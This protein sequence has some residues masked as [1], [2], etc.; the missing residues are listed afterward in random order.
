MISVSLQFGGLMLRERR[1][2]EKSEH[3]HR[4]EIASAQ[5]HRK[6]AHGD[7][8]LDVSLSTPLGRLS[9]RGEI[10]PGE[11]EAGKRYA[12]LALRYLQT[13]GSP[14]PF[15]DGDPPA[16]LLPSDE[17]CAKAKRE[18]DGA[19]EALFNNF[20]RQRPAK[21]VNYIAVYEHEPRD[22]FE[23]DML[24]IGLKA[25]ADYFD[26]MGKVIPFRPRHAL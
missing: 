21:A 13:I 10:S 17:E 6:E 14:Y 19:Y 20:R 18:Y 24:K 12:D 25:L 2:K 15:G 9:F 26:G 3:E 8:V 22:S 5:L 23:L 7:G 11:Y 4:V 16:D 1:G